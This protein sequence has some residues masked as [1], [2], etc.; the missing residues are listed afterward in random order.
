MR[1]FKIALLILGS[2]IFQVALAAKIPVLGNRIDLPLAVLVSLA[3]L[4]GPFYG[5]LVGFVSGLL[6]DLLSDGQ[7]LG[8]QAF[9]RVAIGYCIGF[10]R[11]R[12][13]SDNFITQLASGF[14]A[15]L[16]VKIITSIHL[17]LLFADPQFLRIRFPGLILAA[18]LNSILVV[19]VFWIL[20]KLIRSES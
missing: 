11:G 8:I 5:E 12:L 20:K 15:T 19:A 17:S 2:V 9:S 18:I 14:I 13:Y 1:I 4:R 10:V 6:C 16:A 3:L 7:L